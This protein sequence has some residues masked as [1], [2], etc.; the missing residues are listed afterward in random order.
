MQCNMRREEEKYLSEK[1]RNSEETCKKGTSKEAEKQNRGLLKKMKAEQ[2]LSESWN[3]EAIE[4]GMSCLIWSYYL[5]VR[6]EIIYKKLEKAEEKYFWNEEK[7]TRRENMREEKVEK[8]LWISYLINVNT[9]KRREMENVSG[10][11][12]CSVREKMKCSEN[13]RDKIETEG[14]W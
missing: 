8:W 9:M 6:R 7:P 4:K 5:C 13:W 3:N 10:K 12:S 1:M 14:I 2:K 11:L